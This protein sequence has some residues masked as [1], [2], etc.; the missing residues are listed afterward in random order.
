MAKTTVYRIKNIDDGLYYSSCKCYYITGMNEV[1]IDKLKRTSKYWYIETK[2]WEANYLNVLYFDNIGHYF[3]SEKGAERRLSE[4]T[5]S[6]KSDRLTT[7]GRLLHARFNFVV[8][9]SEIN[10][11]DIP[12]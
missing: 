6:K 2:T 8:V 9:K 7:A 11:E 4:F 1:D 10:I 12:K 5:G 3:P